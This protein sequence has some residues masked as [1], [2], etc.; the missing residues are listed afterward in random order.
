[1]VLI[2]H[3]SGG[4]GNAEIETANYFLEKGYTVG[5]NNYFK[6]HNI[7]LLL[8]SYVD[9]FQDKFEVTF[10]KLLT[11]IKFPS[12]K[13]IVHIGFSLGG[14]LGLLNAKHFTK[15]FIFYPG[16]LGITPELVNENYSN[17]TCYIADKDNWCNSYYE[18]FESF[19]KTPPKKVIVNAYHGFMIPNKHRLIQVSK[20]NFPE[21]MDS[22]EYTKLKPN[23][24]FLTEKYGYAPVEILLQ[25]C[26]NCSIIAL[27]S[28]FKDMTDL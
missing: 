27:N 24:K 11:D 10:D 26:K 1:M 14:Y 25:S 12:Y 6:K 28:I 17:T 3:G 2:S 7:D 20:Y 8:W 22:E 4:I 15:N 5:I 9:K 23:H 18:I 16:I 13:K 19:A 21:R